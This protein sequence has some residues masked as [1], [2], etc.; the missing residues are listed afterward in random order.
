[1]CLVLGTPP[2]LLWGPSAQMKAF[3]DRW[4]ALV[5]GDDGNRLKGKKAII[6]TAYG[7][8]D[9]TTPPEHVIGMFR[10]AFHY[11]GIDLVG[12]LGVTASAPG[13]AARNAQA[14]REAFELGKGG[15]GN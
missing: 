15:L 10:T 11:T 14:M 12:V 5:N 9:P 4:Y 6:V 7:D 8:D 13:D 3:I 1:M 2:V